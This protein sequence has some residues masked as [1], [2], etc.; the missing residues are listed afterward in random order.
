MIS[1][2]LFQQFF[3]NHT[4]FNNFEPSSW[5]R[6]LFLQFYFQKQRYQQHCSTNFHPNQIT[7]NKFSRPSWIPFFLFFSLRLNFQS[8][9]PKGLPPTF[10]QIREHFK[11]S[12]G[13]LESSIFNF[14]N[15]LSNLQSAIPKEKQINQIKFND[16]GPPF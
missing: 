9:L 1:K 15:L 7:F 8:A 14:P 13:H 2:T 16:F 12:V 6:F 11:F 5:I 4:I 10:I 3:S